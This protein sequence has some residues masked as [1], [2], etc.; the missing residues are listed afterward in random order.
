MR[1]RILAALEAAMCLALVLAAM[2][3][4]RIEGVQLG[5]L[6]VAYLTAPLHVRRL[7]AVRGL[8]APPRPLAWLL[9]GAAVA[10]CFAG[11]PPPA[12]AITAAG[13]AALV[14]ALARDDRATAAPAWLHVLGGGS[15]AAGAFAVWYRIG[16]PYPG[17]DLWQYKSVGIV[18]ALAA[19]TLEPLRA[20]TPS[21]PER[22][23]RWLAIGAVF[24]ASSSRAAFPGDV[25]SLGCLAFDSIVRFAARG[26]PV[27]ERARARRRPAFRLAAVFLASLA[28]WA[29][30]ELAFR[31]APNRYRDTNVPSM[32]TW[33]VPGATYV[34]EG[35]VLGLKQPPVQVRWNSRNYH[36]AEH[37]LARPRGTVRVVVLGDS[38]VEGVQVALDD[39]FHR[40]LERGL[41]ARSPVPVE[42][43]ALGWSGWG[44]AQELAALEKEGL[45]YDPSL[46]VVEFL[47]GNDVRNNDD[48]L[49]RLANEQSRQ[50]PLY[51]HALR[52]GLAFSAFVVDRVVVAAR[53]LRGDREALDTDVFREAP[54]R[55]PE[56]W[57]R[58]WARTD[59]LVVE[60]DRVVRGRGGRL[61][62]AIFAQGPEVEAAASGAPSMGEGVDLRR[63]ARRM[64]EI[65]GRRGV[66]CL[67]LAPRFVA[68]PAAERPRLVVVGDGHWS[69][70][71]HE[72]AA[73]E[74]VRFL[75]EDT[76]IWKDVL[77]AAARKD[78]A[79]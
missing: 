34:Y 6:L 64:L 8:A 56:L 27:E 2:H 48:E 59:A 75:T 73:A 71:G 77:D 40:R 22:A 4:R 5:L 9:E 16:H 13:A 30:G 23:L 36:D 21:S 79:Q 70:L 66:P 54:R 61:V 33:H 20:R 55:H 47:P 37:A 26:A 29:L 53:N 45:A 43:I 72:K 25:V 28:L 19:V 10:G 69:A 32:K 50:D 52:E 38:F 78:R 65:C 74:T 62:V 57:A 68:V 49:E 63:P 58:A 24:T 18:L 3:E 31:F 42:A 15:L 14:D 67:D 39:L 1:G 51:L 35:A 46:V 44:Q 76:T 11:S 7:L 17:A 60:L 12:L 41:A